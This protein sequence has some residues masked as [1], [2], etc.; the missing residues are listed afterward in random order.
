MTGE[1]QPPPGAAPNPSGARS[2]SAKPQKVRLDRLLVDRGL[3]PSR[4]KAQA[5]ILAGEVLV[6]HQKIDK[7]GRTVPSEAELRLLAKIPY[8]SRGGLKLEGAL[9]HFHIDPT[10]WTCVDIG[11]STGGFTDCLLQ[12]GAEKV[13]AFDVGKGQLDWKLRNDPRVEVHEGV[14]VRHLTPD[15]VPERFDLAVCD[16][17]FISV[18]LLIPAFAALLK[19]NGRMIVLVKPQFEVG[20]GEVG[21]GGIVRDPQLHRQSCDK[22]RAAVEELW[23]FALPSSKAQ[24]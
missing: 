18:T 13:W 23:D 11:S 10:G 8:V 5:L 24:F 22:V 7:P 14:N 21:K 15:E 1:A 6:D 12:R 4:E 19:P 17:S 20:K 2:K 3:T 9:D 16:A